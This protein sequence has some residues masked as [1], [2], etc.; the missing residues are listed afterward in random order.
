[1]DKPTK[2]IYAPLLSQP[3]AGLGHLPP[4][5]GTRSPDP[6]T[7][8]PGPSVELPGP[9]LLAVA[10]FSARS[11]HRG[12]RP[13]R[14]AAP[15]GEVAPAAPTRPPQGA[16]G[17]ARRRPPS[18]GQGR[19]AHRREVPAQARERQLR[20]RERERRGSPRGR[21]EESEHRYLYAQ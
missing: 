19:M 13:R 17:G 10:Y 18:A 4:D 8:S 5:P 12:G 11:R 2:P 15:R 9:L 3:L 1:M 14:A 6:S 16:E 20:E 21:R 7:C